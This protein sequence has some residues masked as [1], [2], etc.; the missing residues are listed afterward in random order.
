MNEAVAER[1]GFAAFLLRLRA[2]GLTPKNLIAAFESVARRAFL[3]EKFAHLAWAERMLPIDCGEATETP[4]LQALVIAHL[5]IEPGHRVLEIGS[6]TGYTAAVMG[7]LA[8]RVH[9]IERWRKLADG[10]K[11]RV[12]GLGLGNVQIVHGDGSQGAKP[13]EGPFDRIVVWSSFEN[14]PRA[15]VEQLATHGQMIAPVG[16][17]DGVQMLTKLNKVGSR[18]DKE[19]IAPVRLQ[20]MI[21]GA[22]AFL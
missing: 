1:E 8:S 11:T 20:P 13:G 2:Q 3:P 19:E 22:A 7:R 18:F 16:P 15:F 6:G 9:S 5:A 4:D 17:G 21:R 12:E 10:A 14:L